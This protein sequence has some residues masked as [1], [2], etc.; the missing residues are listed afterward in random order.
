M[1]L[2]TRPTTFGAAFADAAA[3]TIIKSSSRNLDE[4][5]HNPEVHWV[6]RRVAVMQGKLG[7]I[8]EPSSRHN[9]VPRIKG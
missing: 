8:T 4:A 5:V 7:T 3:R 2:I 1:E 9:L 6:A